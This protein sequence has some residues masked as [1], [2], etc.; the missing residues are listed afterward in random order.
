MSKPKLHIFIPS[1]PQKDYEYRR[2]DSVLVYDD[3]SNAVLIDGGE[4]QFFDNMVAFMK[5]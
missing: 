4:G 5:R 2:G 1:L 3:L